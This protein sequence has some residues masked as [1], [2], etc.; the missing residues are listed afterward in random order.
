MTLP[1][2][3]YHG[4]G[5][6]TGTPVDR[7]FMTTDRFAEHLDVL[8]AHGLRGVTM[9]NALNGAGPDTIALTFDGGFANFAE[10]AMPMLLSRGHGASLY[11]PTDFV[12]EQATWLG[13]IDEHANVLG[14]DALRTVAAYGIEVGSKSHSH[15]RLDLLT[16]D[17][18]I[19]ELELSKHLLEQELRIP[20][21]GFSYPHGRHDDRVLRAADEAGYR[22]AVGTR[23]RIRRPSD[24]CYALPRVAIEPHHTAE[25][26]ARFLQGRGLRRAP[27]T[28]A[29][30]AQHTFRTWRRYRSLAHLE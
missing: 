20:I 16:F 6:P 9:Q 21:I 28:A 18:L 26:L 1:I 3:S 29:R 12:G 2:L 23:N 8:A 11:V 19:D 24:N 7:W 4:V 22:Y 27:D 17:E 14:W 13:V 25:D 30:M 5:D 10:H 15:R